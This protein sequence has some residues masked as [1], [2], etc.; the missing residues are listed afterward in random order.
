MSIDNGVVVLADNVPATMRF[1][2]MVFHNTTRKDPDTGFIST[3]DKLSAQVIQLNGQNVM[4]VFET[5][6]EKLTAQLR[7]YMG[8]ANLAQ[9]VF[10][11]TKTG[12]GYM[13]EYS[14]TVS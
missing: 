3:V 13:T 10:T 4:T 8:D 12:S 11:I 14:V 6:A 9:R 7:P 2:G 1:S 5:L